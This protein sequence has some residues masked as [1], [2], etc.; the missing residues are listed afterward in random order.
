MLLRPA[1]PAAHQPPPCPLHPRCALHRHAARRCSRHAVDGEHDRRLVRSPSRC[2][3]QA[4]PRPARDQQAAHADGDPGAALAAPRTLAPDDD[5]ICDRVGRP[6]D[7]LEDVFVA[8]LGRDLCDCAIAPKLRQTRDLESRAA[9]ARAVRA[10]LIGIDR[11]TNR[12]SSLDRDGSW[13]PR[14]AIFARPGYFRAHAAAA[15]A[16]MGDF[17]ILS[18]EK[19]RITAGPRGASSAMR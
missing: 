1:T 10:V 9:L 5:A 7:H 8:A 14:T 11:K 2:H 18:A 16:S 4:R 6:P 12:K 3:A 13:E 19:A 17:H 15:Q